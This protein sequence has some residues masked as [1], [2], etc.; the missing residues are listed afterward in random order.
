MNPQQN[1]VPA[2]EFVLVNVFRNSFLYRRVAVN[3][4]FFS[5]AELSRSPPQSP[6]VHTNLRGDTGTEFGAV[7][8]RWS[9]APGACFSG[10]L[11][12]LIGLEGVVCLQCMQN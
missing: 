9:S 5:H 4:L 1:K 2:P 8:I 10:M 3:S 12:V 11:S 6:A 7:W